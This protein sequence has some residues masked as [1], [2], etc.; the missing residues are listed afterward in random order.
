MKPSGDVQAR[1]REAYMINLKDSER[2][3][4]IAKAGHDPELLR[5]AE[6]D[7]QKWTDK[8]QRMNIPG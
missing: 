2:L 5:R 7:R 6:E 3:I 1:L 4:E 8:L